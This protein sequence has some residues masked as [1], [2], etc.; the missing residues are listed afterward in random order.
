[1]SDPSPATM[2]FEGAVDTVVSLKLLRLGA[3][4][5]VPLADALDLI[6]A[7]IDQLEYAISATLDAKEAA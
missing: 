2:L 4:A 5:N 1:M 7:A 3:L 6:E